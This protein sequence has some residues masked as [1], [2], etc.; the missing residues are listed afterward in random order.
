ML[1]GSSYTGGGGGGIGLP[2][3]GVLKQS[4]VPA[5]VTGTVSE[6]TLATIAIPAGAD[7]PN[8]LTRVTTKWTIPS[9]ANTKTP[10][11]R[12][13]GVSGTVVATVSHTTNTT[14]FLQVDI[15]NRGATN[16]QFSQ[17]RG[18]RGTDTVMTVFAPVASAVDMSVAQSVVISGQLGSAGDTM[19]LESYT[20]ELLNP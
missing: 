7:G 15:E 11:I 10:R 13:G 19:T 8:G 2:A 3:S 12:L 14:A 16:S 20:V 6:T 18:N 9:N 5:S 17:P 1:R 4:A